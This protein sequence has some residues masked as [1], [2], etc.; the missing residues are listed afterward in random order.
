MFLRNSKNM[1]TLS[2]LTMRID[3]RLPKGHDLAESLGKNRVE[4][5]LRG[6][7]AIAA[8]LP[9]WRLRAGWTDFVLEELGIVGLH[10]RKI[11]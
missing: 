11:H 8:G 3:A 4:E 10:S 2:G 5:N 6:V 1:L 9:Q 7:A